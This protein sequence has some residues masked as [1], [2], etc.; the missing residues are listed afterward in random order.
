LALFIVVLCLRKRYI[1]LN[2]RVRVKKKTFQLSPYQLQ[3]LP[4]EIVQPIARYVQFL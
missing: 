3:Q 1:R 2:E 4:R